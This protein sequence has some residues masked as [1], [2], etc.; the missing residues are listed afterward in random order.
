[1][2]L[3]PFD[4]PDVEA[5]KIETKALTAAYEKEGRLPAEWPVVRL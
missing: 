2:R 5:S 1:M 3:N 4:Q